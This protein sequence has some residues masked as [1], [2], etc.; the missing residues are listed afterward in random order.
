MTVT[1]RTEDR[2]VTEDDD[3][4]HKP[5]RDQKSDARLVR[6]NAAVERGTPL[7]PAERKLGQRLR[8]AGLIEPREEREQLIVREQFLQQSALYF[9]AAENEKG[10][11]DFYN[12]VYGSG[13]P[14]IS[15]RHLRRLLQRYRGGVKRSPLHEKWIA[16]RNALANAS[17][18]EQTVFYERVVRRLS[19][20][21][22]RDVQIHVRMSASRSGT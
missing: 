14:V 20:I 1:N 2:N 12:V 11:E 21:L 4:C 22:E 3:G 9:V 5:D 17:E 18:E 19:A 13:K 15:E 10:F 7:T 16:F 8:Q 6:W